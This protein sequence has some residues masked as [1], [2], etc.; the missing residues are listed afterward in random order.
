[1]H[2]LP[3]DKSLAQLCGKLDGQGYIAEDTLVITLSLME[4]LQRPLLIEGEAG[5]GKTEI[6][7]SLTAVYLSNVITELKNRCR[8]VLWLNP[9][10]CR[11]GFQLE[12]D[13]EH[14]II[15]KPD[16]LA[17]AHSLDAIK[18]T[19]RHVARITY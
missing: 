16:L 17:S 6:A 18:Q 19:I 10:V 11:E 13:F 7:K 9:M 2:D 3:M 15:P 1:M 5:V 14:Q 12:Q 4:Q 8:Q